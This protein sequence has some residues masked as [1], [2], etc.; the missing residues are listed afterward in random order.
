[1]EIFLKAAAVVLLAVIMCLVIAKRDKDM[2]LILASVACCIVITGALQYLQP[3]FQFLE[4]LQ[5]LSGIDP[6]FFQILLKSVGIGLIAEIAALICADVGNAA[7]GKS[8]QVM[9]TT[10]ILW[11]SLPLFNALLDLIQNILG[12]I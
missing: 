9:A 4:K 10:V 11:L 8:L 6:D 2:A 7:L 3:V 1:M 12:A 5:S